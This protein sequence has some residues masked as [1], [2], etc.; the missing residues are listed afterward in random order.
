MLHFLRNFFAS[1][2][3]EAI[4][5]LEAQLK[6]VS[7]K[8]RMAYCITCLENVLACKQLQEPALDKLLQCL[9]DFTSNPDLSDWEKKIMDFSPESIL[10][11]PLEE[12]SYLTLSEAQHLRT[13]YMSLSKSLLICIDDTIE[14]GRGNLYGGTSGYSPHSLIPAMQVVRYMVAHTYPLP[15][16]ENFLRSPFTEEDQHGWGKRVDRSYF[17]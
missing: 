5:Q 16:M 10:E 11:E 12:C 15:P 2:R 13:V 3:P 17:Q 4:Q 7:I 1:K 14:V 8:G 6:R 9:W